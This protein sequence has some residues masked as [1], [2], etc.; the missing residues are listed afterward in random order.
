MRRISSPGIYGRYAAKSTLNPRYGERWS[1]CTKP[2]T[3]VRAVSSRFWI[4]I[5]TLGSMNRLMD[6]SVTGVLMNLVFQPGL[7]NGNNVDQTF[8]DVLGFDSFRF[9]MEIRQD[10]VPEYRIRQSLN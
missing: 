1:P 9:S 8:N 4:F 5:R 7:W 3:T 10:A 6:C 2:S